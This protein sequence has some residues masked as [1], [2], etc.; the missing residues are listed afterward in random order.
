MKIHVLQYGY[1]HV[2][3][4]NVIK[5]AEMRPAVRTYGS[6]IVKLITKLS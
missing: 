1:Q 5:F 4:I 3:L 2:G 6:R